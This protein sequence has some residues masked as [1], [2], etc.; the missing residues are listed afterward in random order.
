M[1]K[2]M[3]LVFIFPKDTLFCSPGSSIEY[4]AD[5]TVIVHKT[6]I[7][8]VLLKL[9]MAFHDLASSVLRKLFSRFLP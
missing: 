4:P 3:F 8:S 5:G 7:S 1:R 9:A 2:S 6:P